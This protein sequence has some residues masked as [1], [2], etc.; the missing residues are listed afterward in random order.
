VY[1]TEFDPRLADRIKADEQFLQVVLLQYQRYSRQRRHDR[2]LH[3]ATNEICRRTPLRVE[4]S[5]SLWMDLSASPDSPL[6]LP[7]RGDS[8][9]ALTGA[10]ELCE[11][12]YYTW[13]A[14]VA[15]GAVNQRA[16]VLQE[17]SLSES[18]NEAFL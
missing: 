16:W 17:V 18:D 5:D 10:Y 7:T 2:M 9:S 8:L 1:S 6:I 14:D 15:W 3:H 11:V 12:R 4:F 13:E